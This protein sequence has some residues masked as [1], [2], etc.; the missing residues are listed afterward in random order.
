MKHNAFSQPA[1][2][3]SLASPVGILYL[4][5][6]DSALTSIDFRKPAGIVLRKTAESVRAKK[7]LAEYFSGMRDTF[8]CKTAFLSGTPFEQRVWESIRDIPFGETRTYK[9]VAEHI[10]V[11]HAFR[12]V[13]NALGKNPIPI[14]FPCHRVIESSG[15]IGGYSAGLDIKQR[16]LDMEYYRRCALPE[17]KQPASP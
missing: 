11:P 17:N 5:F 1:Y 2:F 15:L 8:T 10:G 6:S 16:L 4:V 14:V 3:D 7:E 13:G 9:W 12:A